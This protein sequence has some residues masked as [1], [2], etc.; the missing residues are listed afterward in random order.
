MHVPAMNETR[1]VEL[2]RNAAARL[3]LISERPGP[4]QPLQ[5]LID[6]IRHVSSRAAEDLR[7]TLAIDYPEINWADEDATNDQDGRPYWLYDP[8]DGAY[9]FIQ[10]LPLWSSSLVLMVDTKPVFSVV[11]DPALMETF[12]A[13]SARGTTC[14]G[15]RLSVS[16]KRD[17][18]AAVVGTSIPPLAQVGREER[19]RAL[20]L[21]KAASDRVFVIRPMAAVSLQLAY[22]AAGRLDA[23]WE[24]GND[25][26]DWL[27]GSLLVTEAGG[28]VTALAG[29]SIATGE[30]LLAGNESICSH[31]RQSF[32][33]TD[34][35]TRS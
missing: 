17:L 23:F 14:N 24:T 30:G 31:L 1:V 25:P 20:T 15:Q 22:V 11:H 13:T 8:I 18:A 29:G 35:E 34:V 33:T 10:D 32:R 4:D 26:G 21:L 28:Q 27:A 12:V 16:R 9:H 6:W 2:V 5:S 3:A 7:N 19:D